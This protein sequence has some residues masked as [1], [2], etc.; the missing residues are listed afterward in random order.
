MI[1]STQWHEKILRYQSHRV[2]RYVLLAIQRKTE[3]D[4]C[5]CCCYSSFSLCLVFTFN[6]R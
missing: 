2:N 4:F 5:C 6:C 3:R 1:K